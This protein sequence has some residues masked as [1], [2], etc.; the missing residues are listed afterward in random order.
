M[1]ILTLNIIAYVYIYGLRTIQ[2]NDDRPTYSELLNKSKFF[3][4]KMCLIYY[5]YFLI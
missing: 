1:C 5:L 4:L 3:L 2:P